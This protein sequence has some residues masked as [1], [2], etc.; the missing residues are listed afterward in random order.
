MTHINWSKM[1]KA[2][3]Y[4]ALMVFL[5]FQLVSNFVPNILRLFPGTTP[6]IFLGL[7]LLL[8]IHYLIRAVE[9]AGTAGVF[10]IHLTY[11]DAFREWLEPY[12]SIKEL[13]IAAYTSY[14]YFEYLRMQPRKIRKVRLLLLHGD[15]STPT[16]SSTR[17]ETEVPYALESVVPRWKLL[18][19]DKKI[20]SLEVRRV[21]SHATFYLSIADDQHVLLG[22]LWPRKGLS[23]LETR[24]ALTFSNNTTSSRELILHTRHWFDCM[25]NTASPLNGSEI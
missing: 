3:L 25:W 19:E 10:K 1:E 20:E 23:E 22:L 14:T 11:L 16:V 15:A 6:Q 7:S 17:A 12:D 5:L 24:E 21:K 8:S 9:N 18:L 13:S 4:I 2:A